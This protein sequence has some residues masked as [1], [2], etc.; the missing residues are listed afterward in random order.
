MTEA[1]KEAT[2]ERVPCIWHPVRFKKDQD[3]TQELIKSDSK[4][5]AINPA[6]AKKLGLRVRQT[7]IGAQKIDGSH[8]ETFGMVIASFSLQDKLGKVRFFQETF[9]VTDTRIE[10]V[11]E[12]FFLTLGNADIRFAEREL[13]WRTYSAAEALSTTRRVEIIDKKEF[14]TA[15][16]NEDDKTFVVHIAALSVGSNIHL[17]RQAQIASL[18]VEEVTIPAEYLDYTDV[19]SPNSVAELPKH[20]GIN[21]HPINLIDDKQPSYGPIYIL[22]PVE[23]E[24]LKTYIE[25]NLANGFIKPSKLPAGALILFILKKDGSLRLCI[26]YQGLNNLTIKNRYPLSLIG[27]SFDRLGRAKCFTQ[28]DLTNAYHQMQI[29]EGDKWKTAF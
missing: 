22:G 18:D 15:V 6:Y 4:V 14:A 29:R 8:L 12:M 10:V 25:T 24:T 1:N 2:L 27:E 9:L 17:S 23:L 21:D 26:D 13:V 28:L 3:D 11:L 5:N 7:D 16:L 20:T 19:F